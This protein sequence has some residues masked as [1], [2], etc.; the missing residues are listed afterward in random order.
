MILKNLAKQVFIKR[1]WKDK[2]RFLGN[3]TADLASSFEGRNYLKD[4][5]KVVNSRFNYA[6][7]TGIN[8][9]LKNIEIGKYSCL[10]DD[11]RT[12]IGIHPSSEFVSIHPVFYST[13][14]QGGFTYI[15]KDRFKVN[16]WIDKKYGISIKVGNDVWIGEGVRLLEGITI[17]DGAII[18]A[19]AI[20]TKDVPPY[21]IVGGV[22]ARI[23]RYRFEPEEIEELL[24]LK[25]WDKEEV[26]IRSHAQYF[27]DVK[28]L[29]K[30]I[31]ENV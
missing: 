9:F 11:I 22:P 31:S 5:T 7:G 24:R 14:Q 3:A 6:S 21:A 25:W 10:A 29:L 15:D 26:W 13:H 28:R 1:R 8:C 27:D 12:I 18:A 4:G 17:G 2:C 30:H 19:G 23:I 16:K 20:V